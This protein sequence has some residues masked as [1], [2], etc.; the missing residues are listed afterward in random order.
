MID[1]VITRSDPLE[2]S[3]LQRIRTAVP[4]WRRDKCDRYHRRVDRQAGLVSFSLLQYLWRRRSSQPMPDIQFGRYGKPHFTGDAHHFNWTHDAS[5]CACVMA[6][7]P[8]GVDVQSQVAFDDGLFDRIA[9][10]SE[11]HLRDRF[12]ATDDISPLWTRKEAVVKRTGR[13]LTVPLRQIDT[14]TADVITYSHDGPPFY[15]SISA[16]GYD[17]PLLRS[18]LRIS[19]LRP[20]ARDRPWIE[21][22]GVELAEVDAVGRVP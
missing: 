22:G 10:P 11:E 19:W 4:A 2:E 3:T 15:L 1:L 7:V 17:A 6:P 9:A 20:G 5:I 12:R 14:T 8:V 13:G 16:A 18:R 21:D